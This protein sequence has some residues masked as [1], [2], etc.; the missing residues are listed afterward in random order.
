[1]S[2]PKISALGCENNEIG[3]V[4]V[5]L[6]WALPLIATVMRSPHNS[7]D[8]SLI[9]KSKPRMVLT[10]MVEMLIALRVKATKFD[11][12]TYLIFQIASYE[13]KGDK[14]V[15]VLGYD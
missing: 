12:L 9:T 13:I 14:D 11:H 1:M 3:S 2:F 5:L 6:W 7:S 10:F 4:T 15:P 8:Q